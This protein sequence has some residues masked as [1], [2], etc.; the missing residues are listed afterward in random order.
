MK[1][2]QTN[3]ERRDFIKKSGT[4]ATGTLL[5]TAMPNMIMCAPPEQ[6]MKVALVGTG[7][8]GINMWGKALLE[9]YAEQI[10]FVGICDINPGRLAYAKSYM[11]VECPTFTDFEQMMTE[12]K[13]DALIVTTVDNTHHEFIIKGMQMGAN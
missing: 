6:K 4:L 12:T 8:R 7:T 13:P 2:D 1:K 9:E 10:E 5:A 3:Q 11:G